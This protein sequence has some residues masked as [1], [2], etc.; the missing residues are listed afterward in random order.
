MQSAAGRHYTSQCSKTISRVC[1][2]GEFITENNDLT[3]KEMPQH[4]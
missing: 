3:D 1:G 4:E 2:I